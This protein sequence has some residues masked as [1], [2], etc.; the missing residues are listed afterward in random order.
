METKSAEFLKR[1]TLKTDFHV[2]LILQPEDML[3]F[4]LNFNESQARCACEC[5]FEI[6]L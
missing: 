1:S 3:H 2:L 5:L 6:N 4:G